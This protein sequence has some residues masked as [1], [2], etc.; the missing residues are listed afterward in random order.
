MSKE[1]T[2]TSK[3][4]QPKLSNV[5]PMDEVG[6]NQKELIGTTKIV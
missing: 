1:K 3:T 4:K 5:E 2:K 6:E